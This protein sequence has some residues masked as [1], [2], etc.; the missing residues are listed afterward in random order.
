MG[1]RP[2]VVYLDLVYAFLP[3]KE[4]QLIRKNINAFTNH[5]NI[6]EKQDPLIIC[7]CCCYNVFPLEIMAVYV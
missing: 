3:I 7:F 4:V 5:I 1:T 6:E 2:C